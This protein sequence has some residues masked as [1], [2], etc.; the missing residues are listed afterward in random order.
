MELTKQTLENTTTR[1][2]F[3][4]VAQKPNADGVLEDKFGVNLSEM[5]SGDSVTLKL[6]SDPLTWNDYG[7]TYGP[8]YL[9]FFEGS[10]GVKVTMF[11]APNKKTTGIGKNLLQRFQELREGDVFTLTMTEKA[12]KGPNAKGATFKL[13]DVQTVADFQV[14][15]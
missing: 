8:S 9:G 12:T 1:P 4:N 15:Q 10:D 7:K 3:I 6:T 14:A 13:Y 2:A 11:V 5:K